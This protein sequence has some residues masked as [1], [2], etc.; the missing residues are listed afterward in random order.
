MPP[1]ASAPPS[2]VLLPGT[3]DDERGRAALAVLEALHQPVRGYVPDWHEGPGALVDQQTW[4]S[5][6]RRLADD[7]L[8][9]AADA[10]GRV[11]TAPLTQRAEVAAEALY[12]EA[13][14]RPMPDRPPWTGRLLVVLGCGRSGT[15]WL[16]SML[17]ASPDAGGVDRA[18]SFLFKVCHGL[19][20]ALPR[21]APVC[22][23]ALLVSSLR[24]FYDTVLEEA[25]AAHSPGASV[26]I[27]KTPLH[28]L[29]VDEIA[30]VYTETH[31]LHLIRDG[32]DV[33]RSISQ[34]PFFQVPDPADA[35][36][37]WRQ[38]VRRV[39][40]FAPAL[41]RYREVRYEDLLSRPVEACVELLAWAGLR[42]DE[43]VVPALEER[44][45]RRVSAHAG[46]SQAVGAGT[47]QSLEHR[48]LDRVL[49]ECGDQLVQE[50]YLTRGA[51]ARH[52]AHPAYVVRRAGRLRAGLEAA[53]RLR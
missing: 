52:V 40:A 12:G 13:P 6:L 19:W 23:R 10:E 17:M 2:L 36:R 43:S 14:P 35:A 16:E 9:P 7:L 38:V 50:G 47:W 26:F 1:V 18:E 3:R 31:F 45:G 8:R 33:A 5:A 53:L 46:T 51:L 28:S 20:L 21:T 24:R 25:M 44:A 15:T 42:H 48:D 49:A 32:R 30:A 11:A 27:E 41:R 4:L 37:L 29:M 22:D 34:V 39:R